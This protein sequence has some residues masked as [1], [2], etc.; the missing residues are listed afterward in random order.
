MDL[1]KLYIIQSISAA[2]NNLRLNA[3]KIEVVAL[4][5]E[6]IIRSDDLENHIKNMKKIT[7]L[8]TLAIRLGEVLTFLT[9][10]PI[11]FFKISEKFKEH[12]QFL[13]KD[14]SHM[15]DMVNPA[16]FK[17]ALHKINPEP[18]Q[19]IEK[20][21]EPESGDISVDLS[22]RKQD[23]AIF[24][25]V[26]EQET[27][28]AEE[29]SEEPENNFHDFESVILKPVKLIDHLL[30]K[31]SE[32]KLDYYELDEIIGIMRQNSDLCNE[33][34]F[35]TL[36]NM[37]IIIVDTLSLIK[38]RGIIP[39]KEIIESI[40]ACLIVIVTIIKGKDVDIA[41]YLARAENFGNQIKTLKEEG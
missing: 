24:E 26:P 6:S 34:G 32:D 13:I 36:A 28:I 16:A 41:G 22:K 23:E 4:L 19:E 39:E 2:S 21:T 35:E 14:L 9:I 30:E 7:E 18:Y 38:E 17:K 5:R 31:I 29:L 1:K 27:V 20:E 40:R 33:K 11:D 15:L 10:G 3:Q 37:H 8:S 25:T 12:S